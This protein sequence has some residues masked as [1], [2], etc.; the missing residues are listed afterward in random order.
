MPRSAKR[1]PR[2]GQGIETEVC[3]RHQQL[4]QFGDVVDKASKRRC[5]AGA[6]WRDEPAFTVDK[7]SKRR[8]V[9]GVI[10]Q[11]LG[12]GRWTRHRNGGVLQ[13]R[14]MHLTQ[15]F[16]WTRHRNGGVLQVSIG[17]VHVDL[18][19]EETSEQG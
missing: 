19:V 10:Q 3:C 7:A 18:A 12:H 8:C 2:G 16:W 9:A 11:T 17:N 4:G 6:F 14:S 13:V 15:A 5:V 1:T